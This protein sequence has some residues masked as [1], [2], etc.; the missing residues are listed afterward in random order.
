VCEGS[1]TLQ[2]YDGNML[3][4]TVSH[5]RDL[6]SRL[7]LEIQSLQKTVK[8]FLHSWKP[9]QGDRGAVCSVQHVD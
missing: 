7:E 2:Q 4:K 9:Q 1:D 5:D 8:V 3:R 6:T